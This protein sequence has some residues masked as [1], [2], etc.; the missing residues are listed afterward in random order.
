MKFTQQGPSPLFSLRRVQQRESMNQYWPK[1]LSPRAG[2]ALEACM[3]FA[4]D[5][6]QPW[7]AWPQQTQQGI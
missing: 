1:T 2:S 7:E 4:N 5:K 6:E 3:R